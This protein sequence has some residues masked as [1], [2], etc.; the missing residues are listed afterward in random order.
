MRCTHFVGKVHERAFCI[1]ALA[2][3]LATSKQAS[4]LDRGGL[5]QVFYPSRSCCDYYGK[6]MMLARVP[7]WD[8]MRCG[9][10]SLALDL[11]RLAR[12]DVMKPDALIHTRSARRPVK[13]FSASE[14]GALITI[15]TKGRDKKPKPS[16]RAVLQGFACRETVIHDDH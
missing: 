6:H 5:L 4:S 10:I 2:A 7:R 11:A 14:T 15:V 9:G 1:S 8:A 3:L 13:S 12:T 16:D